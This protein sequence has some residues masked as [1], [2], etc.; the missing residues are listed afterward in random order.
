MSERQVIRDDA[1]RPVLCPCPGCALPRVLVLLVL[2]AEER[3]HWDAKHGIVDI[4]AA[5]LP[6]DQRAAAMKRT[7]EHAGHGMAVGVISCVTCGYDGM[8]TFGA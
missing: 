5:V 6:P 2:D 3:R 8:Y 7:A 4:T 1:G